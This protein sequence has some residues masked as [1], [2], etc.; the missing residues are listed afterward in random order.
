[1]L[2][3]V[4]FGISFL[5]AVVLFAFGGMWYSKKV[6]GKVMMDAMPE[7]ADCSHMKLPLALEFVSCFLLS[8]GVSFIFGPFDWYFGLINSVILVL[9]IIFPLAVSSYAWCPKRSIKLSL[10]EYGHRALQIIIS[11]ILIG[12]LNSIILPRLLNNG[13]F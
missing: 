5:S 8:L 4:L 2:M 12:W 11:F 10:V 13:I 6:F 1:M 7:G 3:L 9:A